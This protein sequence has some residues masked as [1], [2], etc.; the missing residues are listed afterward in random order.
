MSKIRSVEVFNFAHDIEVSRGQ[1]QE[2]RNADATWLRHV[3]SFLKVINKP[4]FVKTG[5][6]SWTTGQRLNRGNG[7][8]Y[9][10]GIEFLNVDKPVNAREP[11]DKGF[12][13]CRY[14]LTRT[15]STRTSP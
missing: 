4:R 6:S 10:D 11:Y 15:K 9:T 14:T 7:F 12:H 2:A 5:V 1:T 13:K 3:A 8:L